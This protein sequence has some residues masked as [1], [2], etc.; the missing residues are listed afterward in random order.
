MQTASPEIAFEQ[1]RAL[2]NVDCR[3]CGAHLIENGILT[4]PRCREHIQMAS[5]QDVEI[6]SQGRWHCR[7]CITLGKRPKTLALCV[8]I[9]CRFCKTKTQIFQQGE[10]MATKTA[11]TKNRL[12]TA[13]FLKF[14]EKERKR[15][16]TVLALTVGGTAEHAEKTRQA[17]QLADAY[18]DFD[19]D[20]IERELNI[21]VTAEIGSRHVVFSFFI[22]RRSTQAQVFG[23]AA[24][25]IGCRF[26]PITREA[27]IV[28]CAVA[29]N[30]KDK[31]YLLQKIYIE[32]VN[33]VI[34]DGRP[35]FLGIV[36]YLTQGITKRVEVPGGLYHE[37][38]P[39]ISM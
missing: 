24:V 18:E 3:G 10:E 19:P 16:A 27:L 29:L 14:L 33:R 15:A 23:P 12:T 6:D 1:R 9:Q 35:N 17:K 7:K 8:E 20:A 25:R 30:M 11:E 32:R 5:S 34:I 28:V 4:C 13:E 31:D 21:P 26:N 36:F 38:C 39:K 37:L 22:L 2:S